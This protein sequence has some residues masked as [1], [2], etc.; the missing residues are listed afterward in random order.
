MDT[1]EREIFLFLKSYGENFVG[2]TEI[3]RRAGG[4]KRFHEDNDWAKPILLRM[5]DRHIL[6]VDP[7]GDYRIK[8]RRK[9]KSTKWV[10]PDIAKI[11]R[12]SG[13][14]TEESEDIA[15]DDYY[16]QL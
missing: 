16:E 3:C 12:E 10:A 8:R 5:V 15:A 13:V 11:L 14:E 9:P 1:D 2:P 6:E 7:H 4:R